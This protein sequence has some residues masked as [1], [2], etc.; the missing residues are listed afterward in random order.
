M[1][2]TEQQLEALKRARGLEYVPSKGAYRLHPYSEHLFTVF[3]KAPGMGR[4][5]YAEEIDV[6]TRKRSVTEAKKVAEVALHY[7]FT[8]GL[9]PSRVVYRGK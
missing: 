1:R 4:G 5:E 8:G 7:N 6:L 3:T 2:T 9:K